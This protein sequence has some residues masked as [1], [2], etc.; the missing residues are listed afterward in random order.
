[1]KR[2]I[3]GIAAG[4]VLGEVRKIFLIYKWSVVLNN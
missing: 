3:A 1:M 2:P 4:F